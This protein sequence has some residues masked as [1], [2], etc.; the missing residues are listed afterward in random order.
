MEHEVTLKGVA[1]EGKGL[2][3]SGRTMWRTTLVVWSEFDPKDLE[4]S[5]LVRD[6]ESGESYIAESRTELVKDRTQ[7]PETEFFG[8]DYLDERSAPLSGAER[9]ALLDEADAGALCKVF[10]GHWEEH[11]G[12]PVGDWRYECNSD[13]SRLGYWEWVAAQ[14]R[15]LRRDVYF[16][17]YDVSADPKPGLLLGSGTGSTHWALSEGEQVSAVRTGVLQM[18]EMQERGLVGER[19]EVIVWADEAKTLLAADPTA[20]TMPVDPQFFDLDSYGFEDEIVS[21]PSG[22]KVG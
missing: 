1:D 16:E 7:W 5:E 6:A 12:Y 19:V 13:D 22:P 9:V 4:A 14:D 15:P 11:P 2:P 3:H 17:I 8:E 20:I 21:T 18:Q 10:G